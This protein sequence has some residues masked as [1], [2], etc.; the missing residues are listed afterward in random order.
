MKTPN[1]RF[2]KRFH[3]RPFY[4][5]NTCPRKTIGGTRIISSVSHVHLLKIFTFSFSTLNNTELDIKTNS[6]KDSRSSHFLIEFFPAQLR[7]RNFFQPFLR[8]FVPWRKSFRKVLFPSSLR[9]ISC[10]SPP[11]SPFDKLHI[12]PRISQLHVKAA[13]RI[14]LKGDSVFNLFF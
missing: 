3:R 9:F 13:R 8:L 2:S 10:S 11:P 7:L 5:K 1:V 12:A 4:N 14:F 6:R